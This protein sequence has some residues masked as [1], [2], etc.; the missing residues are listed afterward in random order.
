VELSS[1]YKANNP[2]FLEMTT[3]ANINLQDRASSIMGQL[4]S[5]HDHTIII[6]PVIIRVVAYIITTLAFNKNINRCISEEQ[7]IKVA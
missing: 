7:I 4:N 1:T 2:F 6:I 3:W 5:F